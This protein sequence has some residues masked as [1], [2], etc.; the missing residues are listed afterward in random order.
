MIIQ[1]ALQGTST[2]APKN[3]VQKTA[4]A[5]GFSH[6][7]EKVKKLL[8]EKGEPPHEE[9]LALIEVVINMLEAY[10]KG[11]A[12][13]N[14]KS[15]YKADVPA[16]ASEGS[17][18][19]FVKLLHLLKGFQ[20]KLNIML[21][22]TPVS[23]AN[24]ARLKVSF[25]K[26]LEQFKEIVSKD[27]L[28]ADLQKKADQLLKKAA[29]LINRKS[30]V[31]Q[32]T[33]FET[34][35]NTKIANSTKPIAESVSQKTGKTSKTIVLEEKAGSNIK[36][37]SQKQHLIDVVKVDNRAKTVTEPLN[38]KNNFTAERILKEPLEGSKPDVQK[39]EI[40]QNSFFE[41]KE[42]RAV[43]QQTLADSVVKE[44]IGV[45]SQHNLIEQIVSKIQFNKDMTQVKIDLKPETLG[46][47]RMN[48]VSEN[49][50]LKASMLVENNVVK[51]AIENNLSHLKQNLENMGVSVQE[52]NVEVDSGRDFQEWQMQHKPY[53]STIKQSA[54]G[55]KGAAHSFDP[56]F[57][58]ESSVNLFV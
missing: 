52:F 4:D 50:T 7:I 44:G 18:T 35:L 37:H 57:Y 11:E 47:V 36:T 43:Q 1:E 56:W 12:A 16:E 33:P 15:F 30:D 48:I 19:D 38:R 23:E 31:S 32:K 10:N 21:T 34:E 39:P 24:T 46:K 55:E 29:G 53:K 9:L 2:D 22:K 54:Q 17:N 8:S 27:M 45:K 13:V 3:K 49:G 58:E 20:S 28:P 41:V 6:E 42:F 26:E 51:H 14:K 5:P 40:V 25:D